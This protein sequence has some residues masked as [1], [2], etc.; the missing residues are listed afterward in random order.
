MGVA[1]SVQDSSNDP[2]LLV[3]SPPLEWRQARFSDFLL[4]ENTTEVMLLPKLYGDDGFCPEV[5]F[6][7]PSLSNPCYGEASCC[8]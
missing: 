8:V 7:V 3:L 5:L 1:D 4:V 6:L 2:R